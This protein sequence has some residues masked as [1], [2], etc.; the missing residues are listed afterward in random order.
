MYLQSVGWKIYH[1]GMSFNSTYFLTYSVSKIML[2]VKKM[3]NLLAKKRR[4]I[5]LTCTLIKFNLTAL[6]TLAFKFRL[7]KKKLKSMRQAK[8]WKPCWQYK[9][10]ASA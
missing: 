7:Y 1:A 9:D 4:F 3:E 2:K 8:K 10:V 5:S 6:N